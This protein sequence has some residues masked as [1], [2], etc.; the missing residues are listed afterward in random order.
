M[1][2]VGNRALNIFRGY[3]IKSY[4]DLLEMEEKDLTDLRGFGP[5]C[6]QQVVSAL[7]SEGLKLKHPDYAARR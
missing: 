1:L 3:G 5:T 2:D 7:A 4:A 6:L